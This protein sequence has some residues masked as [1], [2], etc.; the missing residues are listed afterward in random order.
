MNALQSG[1]AFDNGLPTDAEA[2][3]DTFLGKP[4][5]RQWSCQ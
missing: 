1:L 2:W 3:Q 4:A 5:A